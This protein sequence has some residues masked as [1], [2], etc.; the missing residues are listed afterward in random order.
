MR[1][2]R[3]RRRQGPEGGLTSRV[4][5]CPG[6]LISTQGAERLGPPATVVALLRNPSEQSKH[7]SWPQVQG[8]CS[9]SSE[10]SWK[11][12][13]E[14]CGLSSREPSPGY[15]V[16]C[17]PRVV[18]LLPATGIRR[19]RPELAARP[20]ILDDRNTAGGGLRRRTVRPHRARTPFL[21]C[22]R[23]LVVDTG[24]GATL[25]VSEL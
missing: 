9:N 12:T 17:N 1:P 4:P 21:Q 6:I 15:P 11:R 5:R 7:T 19:G 23:K 8:T 14:N 18:C 16:T 22:V 25:K 24:S 10:P 20:A 2:S 13:S 3:A